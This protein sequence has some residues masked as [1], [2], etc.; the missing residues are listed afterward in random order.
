MRFLIYK[1]C[2]STENLQQLCALLLSKTPCLLNAVNVTFPDQLISIEVVIKYVAFI[3]LS[4]ASHKL[5]D[6]NITGQYNSVH[7]Y[8]SCI[9]IFHFIIIL[10]NSRRCVKWYVFP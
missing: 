2:G 1:K 5:N 3:R 6:M 10:S 4:S 9:S 7:I 8:I